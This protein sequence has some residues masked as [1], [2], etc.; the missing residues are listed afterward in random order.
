MYTTITTEQQ[1][2][3]ENIERQGFNSGKNTG[4]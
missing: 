1:H 3:W 2:C 4:Q